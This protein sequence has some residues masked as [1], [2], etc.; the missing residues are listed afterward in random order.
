MIQW[1]KKHGVHTMD[2]LQKS[3]YINKEMYHKVWVLTQ[4]DWVSRQWDMPPLSFRLLRDA[5]AHVGEVS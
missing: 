1:R 4:Y 3:F 2:T 5:K